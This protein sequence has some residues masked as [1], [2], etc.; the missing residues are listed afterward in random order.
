MQR[1]VSKQSERTHPFL[2]AADFFRHNAV[3]PASKQ[4]AFSSPSSSKTPSLFLQAFFEL[5]L[6]LR[7]TK[8]N[9]GKLIG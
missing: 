7:Q 8:I 4:T 6:R 9:R 3:K 5:S 1:I 2:Q